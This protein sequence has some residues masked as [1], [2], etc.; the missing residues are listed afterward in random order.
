MSK[1]CEV[2]VGR[3]YVHAQLSYTSM[4]F[5]FTS[6]NVIQNHYADSF[7][8]FSYRH[9]SRRLRKS[10]QVSVCVS[11]LKRLTRQWRLC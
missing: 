6:C 3:T 7:E 4:L 11:K 9:D 8:A 10:R 5:A 2:S 1:G